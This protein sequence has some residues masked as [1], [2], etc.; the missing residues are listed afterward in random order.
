MFKRHQLLATSALLLIL[1]GC[2]D[3][4]L[5]PS[6]PSHRLSPAGAPSLTPPA[7]ATAS[8]VSETQ[9]DVAWV[10]NSTNE[11][12]FELYRSTTGAAGIYTL[13]ATPG[14]N[15]TWYSDRKLENAPVLC[16][17]VRA[18]RVYGSKK[19]VSGFSNAACAMTP[20]AAPS[21]LS[22]VGTSWPRVNLS[23]QDNASLETNFQVLRSTDGENGTFN[24]LSWASSD[25]VSLSDASVTTGTRYCYRVRAAR[26]YPLSAPPEF[27]FS[28]PSN[29][30]CA[31]PPPPSAPPPAAYQVR[32]WPGS[33]STVV[34]AL[35]WTD[36]SMPA[37]AFRAY[38]SSDGGAHW[39]Q[40]TL[41]DRGNG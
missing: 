8:G 19:Q 37:S 36:T 27:V 17:Q 22:A 5:A 38:R 23:W 31:T 32:T 39:T 24:V 1:I 28:S 6:E 26:Q 3:P 20:P 21:N 35:T 14:S 41:V 15:V 16:Y 13:L 29:A 11:T 18:I 40:V 12:S 9:I 10:D 34:V 25:A 30:A 4:A 7:N 33:S 2:S